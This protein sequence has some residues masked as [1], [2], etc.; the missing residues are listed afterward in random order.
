VLAVESKERKTSNFVLATLAFSDYTC[1]IPEP[2]LLLK[3]QT[4]II[5]QSM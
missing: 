5:T 1:D 3:Q 2:L 4:K